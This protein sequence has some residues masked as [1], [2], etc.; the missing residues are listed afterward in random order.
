LS[1]EEKMDVVSIALQPATSVVE[2]LLEQD[3]AFR[4]AIAKILTATNFS[5]NKLVHLQLD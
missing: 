2:W 3:L 1:K 4:T 5:V